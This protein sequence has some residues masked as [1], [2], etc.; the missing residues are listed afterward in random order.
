MQIQKHLKLMLVQ[1]CSIYLFFRKH[2]ISL[3]IEV[4]KDKL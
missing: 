1:F 2:N 3:Q 4:Y